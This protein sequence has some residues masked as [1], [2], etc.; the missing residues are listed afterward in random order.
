[1]EGKHAH[2]VWI[3]CAEASVFLVNQGSARVDEAHL[4]QDEEEEQTQRGQTAADAEGER[5]ELLRL[6]CQP[7]HAQDPDQ[8]QHADGR[9][10][11]VGQEEENSSS[12]NGRMAARSTRTSGS[13][14]QRTRA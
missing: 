7:Q 13:R 10:N 4:Q 1:M 14:A 11:G 6:L 3:G 12:Q 9:E 8:P 2:L 5:A